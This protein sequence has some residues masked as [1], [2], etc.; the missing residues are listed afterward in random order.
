MTNHCVT[1]LCVCVQCVCVLASSGKMSEEEKEHKKGQEKAKKKNRNTH[2]K[3]EEVVKY[4]PAK[5]AFLSYQEKKKG[6]V[7]LHPL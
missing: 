7:T 1:A 4:T 5:I 6:S 3:I 2:L